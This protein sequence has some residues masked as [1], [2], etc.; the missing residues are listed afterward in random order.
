MKTK[1]SF[2]RNDGAQEKAAEKMDCQEVARMAYELYEQR[3]RADGQ[4]LEDWLKAEAI[5]KQGKAGEPS[6][7]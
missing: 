3:G 7:R 5:V 2:F 6:G 4:D 1:R